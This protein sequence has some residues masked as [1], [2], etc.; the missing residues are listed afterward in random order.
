MTRLY[1][2][3][4]PLQTTAEDLSML[5]GR[6]CP[7]E[8]IYFPGKGIT[9]I[10]RQFAI[11]KV[12]GVGN[13]DPESPFKQCI[14][15]LNAVRWKG[16]KLRVEVAKE[17]FTERLER[18]RKEDQDLARLQNEK[19]E[20]RQR[21]Y[22]NCTT[23][24]E[25]AHRQV[26]AESCRKV[27][28]GEVTL[29]DNF[30]IKVAPTKYIV[31]R[32]RVGRFFEDTEEGGVVLAKKTKGRQGFGTLM[33]PESSSIRGGTT[34]GSRS[35]RSGEDK[36][37][38]A[39]CCID[40]TAEELRAEAAATWFSQEGGR[41][42]SEFED[43]FGDDEREE[44]D[45]LE[46]EFAMEAGDADLI[47]AVTS[48]E[49]C[50]DALRS[51]RERMVRMLTMIGTVADLRLINAEEVEGGHDPAAAG[52]VS[53]AADTNPAAAEAQSQPAVM[54]MNRWANFS[55]ARFD[56]LAEDAEEME[57]SAEAVAAMK[58]K[59]KDAPVEEAVDEAAVIADGGGSG[60]AG[61]SS[62]ADLGAM[63][64]LFGRE[65][66]VWWEGGGTLDGQVVKGAAPS[67]TLFAEA[68]KTGIDVRDLG[69]KGPESSMTFDFF[70]GGGGRGGGGGGDDGSQ[71]AQEGA[72]SSAGVNGLA[73][74]AA[75]LLGGNVTSTRPLPVSAALDMAELSAA[76]PSLHDALRG[77]RLF[78]RADTEARIRQAWR[79]SREKAVSDVK[80]RRKD[81]R[82][83]VAGVGSGVAAAAATAGAAADGATDGARPKWVK[84][85]RGGVKRRVGGAKQDK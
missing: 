62:F 60:T 46:R 57:L 71:G 72:S 54:R 50:E 77:A 13:D 82:K 33:Q 66:G 34:A 83:R 40:G 41:S 67:D 65:G 63:K 55:G 52:A 53:A 26:L 59:S 76:V 10:H 3:N 28:A 85:R 58:L 30:R 43:G 42:M 64:G 70:G 78:S 5:V 56:P 20:A 69:D 2:G 29:P 1:V 8:D 15:T 48:D 51:E 68:E 9:G 79:D 49:V 21:K 45:R 23:A 7:V 17:F 84:K 18:E 24:A 35:N 11:V 81:A 39:K 44:E 27:D 14:K 6:I 36:D 4:L 37:D 22:G 16:S 32:S 31:C 47:P 25:V 19:D 80:R 74:T 61:I 38:G 73:E 75:A 12:P